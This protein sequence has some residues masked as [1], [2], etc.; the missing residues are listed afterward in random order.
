MTPRRWARLLALLVATQAV[1]LVFPWAAWVMIVVGV[2]GF[3]WTAR[4]W[5]GPTMVIAPEFTTLISDNDRGGAALEAARPDGS[6]VG[7]GR[8]GRQAMSVSMRYRLQ[9]RHG[10]PYPLVRARKRHVCDLCDDTIPVGMRHQVWS[11]FERGMPPERVRAHDL[12]IRSTVVSVMSWPTRPP[13][14]ERLPLGM[15]AGEIAPG[16]GADDW[17]A[18]IEDNAPA[19]WWDGDTA[20]VWPPDLHGWLISLPP[21][22]WA[23]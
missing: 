2:L 3:A 22:E 6:G 20:H 8:R 19:A 17:W 18:I 10:L 11:W 12:C 13:L 16:K 21:I 15:F 5:S 14:A 7:R 23:S 1:A 9:V 4:Y